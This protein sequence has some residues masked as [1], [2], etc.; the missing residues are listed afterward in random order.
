MT[1]DE[2]K[3]VPPNTVVSIFI[4]L[5][6]SGSPEGDRDFDTKIAEEYKKTHNGNE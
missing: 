3:A 2:E 1:K 6:Q 4:C 5:R